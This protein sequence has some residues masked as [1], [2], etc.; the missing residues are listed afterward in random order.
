MALTVIDLQTFRLPDA[1]T[2]PLAAVGVLHASLA[3]APPLWHLASAAIG[4]LALYAVSFAYRHFRGRDGLGLGD[5]KLLG[6]AGAWVGAEAL[7]SILLMAAV[8]A[9]LVILVLRIAGHKLSS[10]DAIPFGPFL[11]VG[12]WIAWTHG[13][14]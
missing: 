4:Y 1:V 10:G 9:L 6:A 3:D 2:L 11:A 12:T 14:F 13:T 7:P 8:S 5:A